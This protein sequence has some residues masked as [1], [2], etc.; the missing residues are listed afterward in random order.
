MQVFYLDIVCYEGV[1]KHL[2][3]DLYDLLQLEPQ[4]H[5]QAGEAV[6]SQFRVFSV[7]GLGVSV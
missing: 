7:S 2:E 5:W 4:H 1:L 6:P 3:L